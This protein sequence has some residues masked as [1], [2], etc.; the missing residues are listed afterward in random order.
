MFRRRQRQYRAL[1][2]QLDDLTAALRGL[3]AQHSAEYYERTLREDPR[4]AVPKRLTRHGYKSFSQSDE[5]GILREIFRRIGSG[6]TSFVEFGVGDGVENNTCALL[7]EGWRGTWIEASADSVGRIED[8]FAV[9]IAAGQLTITHTALTAENVAAVFERLR[10][11]ADF[12]L[13]SIDVDGN[14]YWIWKALDA[15]RPRVVAIEYNAV[16]P[17]DTFWVMKYDPAFTWRGTSYHG[18]SLKALERLGAELGYSLV[19]CNFTGV[20][21]FFVRA[22]LVGDH[23]AAPFTAEHHYEPARG[24]YVHFHAGPPREFGDFVGPDG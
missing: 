8:R 23:F 19:G 3:S 7:H 9:P 24:D 1:R 13:L 16:F 11:P 22:D 14:D 6:D 18:A 2:R 5:D 10:V 20:N 4:Y 21:A 17:A 15:Y 12:D